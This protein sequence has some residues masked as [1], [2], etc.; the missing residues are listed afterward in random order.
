M[1]DAMS[2]A[3]EYWN[4]RCEDCKKKYPEIY[5]KCSENSFHCLLMN[6]KNNLI[7]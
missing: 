7:K 5:L 2:D 1:T 4:S 6:K 3:N